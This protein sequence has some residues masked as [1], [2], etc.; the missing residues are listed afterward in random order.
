MYVSVQR[1]GTCMAMSPLSD[2]CNHAVGFLSPL[3]L[4]CKD[5]ATDIKRATLTTSLLSCRLTQP[6][7]SH[8]PLQ[9]F[10]AFLFP[11]PTFLSSQD[12]TLAIQH[13]SYTTFFPQIPK[14]HLDFSSSCTTSSPSSPSRHFH[15]S[16]SP[17]PTTH[18]P[19]PG[20]RTS[21]SS[22]VPRAA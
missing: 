4:A 20:T 9:D 3:V 6:Q 5:P 2:A 10:F 21:P 15:P 18:A 22:R 12:I 14:H 17:C 11:T 8:L 1:C 7:H 13:Q 19:P 16:Q